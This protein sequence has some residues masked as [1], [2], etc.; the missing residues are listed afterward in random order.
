MP[1]QKTIGE[2]SNDTAPYAVRC[3]EHV[4]Y[5]AVIS[6]DA[7]DAERRGRIMYARDIGLPIAPEQVSARRQRKAAK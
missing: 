3:G 5:D 6:V 7:Y 4:V 1:T 2:D